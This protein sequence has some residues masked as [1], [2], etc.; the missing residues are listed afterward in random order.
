M[1]DVQK[2]RLNSFEL[3]QKQ[4]SYEYLLV[5]CY[6]FLV[7]TRPHKDSAELGRRINFLLTNRAPAIDIAELIMR[8]FAYYQTCGFRMVSVIAALFTDDGGPFD[9][10]LHSGH[11]LIFHH[12]F[13]YS[14]GATKCVMVRFPCGEQLC[15]APWV[16]YDCV[17]E[18]PRPEIETVLRAQ[19][20]FKN[21]SLGVTFPSYIMK[22]GSPGDD[23]EYVRIA[24]KSNRGAFTFKAS[25]L[26]GLFHVF[27][28]GFPYLADTKHDFV[29]AEHHEWLM[30]YAGGRSSA[31]WLQFGDSTAIMLVKNVFDEHVCDLDL[32]IQILRKKSARC[33]AP[34]D[35]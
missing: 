35:S 23:H 30:L 1:K 2:N 14:R 25:E 11:D 13:V 32:D 16:G 34:A 4:F 18:F 28:F 29:W 9:Q 8:R 22:V 21:V 33:L 5:K 17:D 3:Q 6:P 19:L 10:L 15:I 27:V 7:G 20:C 31:Q 12:Y 26:A 24:N